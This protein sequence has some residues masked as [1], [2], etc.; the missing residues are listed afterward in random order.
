MLASGRKSHL[1]LAARKR[2]LGLRVHRWVGW[3]SRAQCDWTWL[4]F[5]SLFA[6][7]QMRRPYFSGIWVLRVAGEN[8]DSSSLSLLGLTGGWVCRGLTL[9]S[10][11]PAL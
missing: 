8:P 9:A 11:R 1:S 6:G 7:D 2:R 10:S 3:A 4:N 5:M